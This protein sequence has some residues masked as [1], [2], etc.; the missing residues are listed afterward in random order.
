[1][2]AQLEYHTDTLLIHGGLEPGSS[3]A[4]KVPI[5]QSSSF[6]HEYYEDIIRDFAQAL[7]SL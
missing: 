4:T 5:V 3:G 7:D 6:A 2:T 1:M